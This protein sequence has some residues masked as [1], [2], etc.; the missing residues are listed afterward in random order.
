MPAILL[1]GAT[2]SDSL[3]AELESAGAEMDRIQ[4]GLSE[5]A[6]TDAQLAGTVRRW[7]DRHREAPLVLFDLAATAHH[8]SVP[9][10]FEENVAGMLT[11]LQAMAGGEHTH[12]ELVIVTRGAATLDHGRPDLTVC[13][14]SALLQTTRLE[15]PLL[16]S[17]WI[18]LP[19]DPSAADLSLLSTSLFEYKEENSV[20]MRAGSLFVPRLRAVSRPAAAA[21]AIRKDSSYLVTGA[22]SGLGLH[23]VE[24]LARRGAGCIALMGR[25]KP[26]PE[27]LAKMRRIEEA[28]VQLI[29][30]TG[31]VARENDINLVFE[32]IEKSGPPLRGVIHSAGTTMD[33]TLPLQDRVTLGHVFAAKVYGAWNLHQRSLS[34]PLDFFV[35][36]GSAASTLGSAGQANH[37]AANAFLD[38]LSTYRA[39]L[40]LPALTV[41]WGPWS[42]IGAAT[43]VKDTGRGTRAGIRPMSP[44]EGM[45]LLEQALGAG[46]PSVCALDIDWKVYQAYHPAPSMSTFLNDLLRD[47]D[48]AMP[49]RDADGTL[50]ELL[51]AFKRERKTEADGD[52]VTRRSLINGYLSKRILAALGLAP[53]DDLPLE[54]GFAELG[55][56]SLMALELKNQI[57]RELE[58]SL[59]SNFFFEFSN[60]Q[61]AGEAL[62]ALL[63]GEATSSSSKMMAHTEF[64]EFVL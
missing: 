34:R 32:R 33:A 35:L 57:Q 4:V 29:A 23:A 61:R 43:R 22:Y 16:K 28:G 46:N 5:G 12:A 15:Y 60:L 36:Y 39:V 10:I 18:D 41:G 37:A 6:P 47:H 54:Q 27:I 1:L 11:M 44:E 55:L 50:P 9:S 7:L 31:D 38:S 49:D 17:R 64:E 62:E 51:R 13:A 40:G 56:D 45:L 2:G 3:S 59:P 53:T 48:A 14:A 30:C 19:L 8:R 52:A 21:P 20:A 26:S 58:V 24:W 42:E 63:A 25:N